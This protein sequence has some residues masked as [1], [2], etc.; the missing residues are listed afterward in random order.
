[1][2]IIPAITLLLAAGTIFSQAAGTPPEEKLTTGIGQVQ[3]VFTLP[4]STQEGRDPF[5]PESTRTVE[6]PQANAHSVEIS[7][8]KVPGISGTPGHLF[9]IINNHT[10]AAGE[11]GDVKT[12]TGIV[13]I[14]CVEIQNSAVV[15]E[16]NGQIHRLN[17]G[18][19]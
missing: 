5:F 10:F 16:I 15:V 8:L 6:T 14:R 7:S 4:A 11:E 1:M 2:K 12:A 13:H 19:Q 17:V 3:S 18:S 9:A